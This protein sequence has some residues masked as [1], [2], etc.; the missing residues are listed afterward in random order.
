MSSVIVIDKL[1]DSQDSDMLDTP[2]DFP[3]AVIMISLGA[4]KYAAVNATTAGPDPMEVNIIAVFANDNEAE[5]WEQKWKL[6]GERVNKKFNEARD[7][8]VSKPNVYGLG[9]QVNA[10]TAT[11]HWVR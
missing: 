4:G 11:I 9:L 7:I 2:G 3:D 1:I 5:I 6:T 10:N 8:A